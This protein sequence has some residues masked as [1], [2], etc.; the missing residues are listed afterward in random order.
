MA[1]V[2]ESLLA[3]LKGSTLCGHNV[4]FDEGM[5]NANL[6]RAGIEQRVPYHKVDTVTLAHEHLLSLG[7]PRLGM[8]PIRDF[9]GW[10]EEGSH[11]AMQDAPRCPTTL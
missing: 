2:G 5:L 4:S 11:T 1:E 10:G 3:F 9:L 6:K 8:D 7:L